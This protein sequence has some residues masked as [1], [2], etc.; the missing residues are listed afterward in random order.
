MLEVVLGNVAEVLV[1][2][3]L[4]ETVVVV[5]VV[6]PEARSAFY[7]IV[8]SEQLFFGDLSGSNIRA[9]LKSNRNGH[10]MPSKVKI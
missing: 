9:S 2:V 10:L 7:P 8:V 5:G 6:R 3:E 4:V 1:V